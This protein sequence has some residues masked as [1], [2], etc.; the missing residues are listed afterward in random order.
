M[1]LGDCQAEPRKVVVIVP[2]KS[3]KQAVAAPGSVSKDA[4]VVGLVK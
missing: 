3:G 2:A 4:A 1:L